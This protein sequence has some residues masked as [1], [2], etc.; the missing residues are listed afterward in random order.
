VASVYGEHLRRSV[1]MLVAQV[2]PGVVKQAVAEAELV[3]LARS[4]INRNH[5]MQVA[6]D[7]LHQQG[8]PLDRAALNV[9][10]RNP[11]IRQLIRDESWNLV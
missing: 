1:V 4:I 6:R 7:S 9:V 2:I 5:D 10:E 3:N 11:D 8:I